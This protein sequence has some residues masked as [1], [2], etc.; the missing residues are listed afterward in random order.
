MGGEAVGENFQGLAEWLDRFGYPL[1]FAAVF[2]EN[3]GLPV[4]GETAVLV[5]GLLAS[6]AGSPLAI[7]WVI[8]V[9][10]LAAVLGDN[11]GFWLGRRWARGR[12]ERGK[13]FL[14]LTPGT[15]RIVEGYFDHYGTLTVFFAR[16]VAGLRVV[17]ALA[18]GTSRM[19]WPRFI[20]A[21]AAGAVAWGVSMSL[22]GYFFG[23]SWQA[24]HRWLGRGVLVIL[25]CTVLLVGL[26][27]LWRRARRL[28]AGSWNRLLR[29]QLWQGLLAAILVVICVAVLVQLAEHHAAPPSE[30]QEVKQWIAV[31]DIPWLNA[32]AAGG[33]YLGS[34][35]VVAPVVV[36]LLIWSW[37]CG[38][39][40]REAVAVLWALAAGEGVGLI[41]L[42]LLRHE[43]VEPARALAWPFGFAGLAPLRGAAVF[44]MM[45]HVLRRQ[46][47]RWGAAVQA[48]AALAVL[49]IGFSVVWTREQY[50][51]EVLVEYVIG[52]LVLFAGLWWL[53]GYGVVP[54]LDPPAA[55]P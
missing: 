37:C 9:T 1:L 35:V 6:R 24:L 7:G 13:R 36:L 30:D 39:P 48:L 2:A 47:P 8:A 49:L 5:A 54:P 34:L 40:W 15:L 55:S 52:S 42:G 18:A 50:L 31:R 53:E 11:L 20:L 10:I 14:F 29:S 43:G 21:N 12:L 19:A 28:P 27:Y 46:L 3:V 26:P 22:L 4:P 51:T 38:R 25:A 32:V 45:A 17:A 23:Q 41:L 33:S 44:G 16:F